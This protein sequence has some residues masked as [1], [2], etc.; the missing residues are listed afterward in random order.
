MSLTLIIVSELQRPLPF[1]LW[2][3]ANGLVPLCTVTRS[4]KFNDRE[5]STV[6]EGTPVEEQLPRYFAKSG[7]V[8]ADPKGT[9]KSGGGKANW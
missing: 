3:H 9:K 6:A 5:H 2:E 4:H 7:H 8:D 1:S